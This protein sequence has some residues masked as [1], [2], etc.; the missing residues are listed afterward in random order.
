MRR[1]FS[2]W[3]ALALLLAITVPCYAGAAVSVQAR[4]AVL[5]DAESGRVL[6]AKEAHTKARIA[7]TTKLL[8]ALVAAERTAD[9]D[10]PIPIEPQWTGIEG[11][12]ICLKPG[13]TVS[14][15]L[16]LYGLL[17]Q[18]GNDAAV[19]I[20]NI[21]AGSEEDFAA[22]M[23]QRAAEIGMADSSFSNAS[24]LDGENHYSTAYDMALLARA[25]LANETVR[26]ICLARTA[27]IGERYF[28]NHNKLLSRYEGCIGMKTGYT[29]KAGR[30]LVSAAQKNGQTL[31][32][33]TLNDP[34]DWQDHAALL[35]YGFAAYPRASLCTEGEVFGAVPVSGSLIPS[36]TAVAHASAGYP[37]GAGE[38][39]E[40]SVSLTPSLT[41]PVRPGLAVGQVTWSLNGTTVAEVPLVSK[42]TALTDVKEPLS[43]WQR[44]AAFFRDLF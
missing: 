13:E 33:V 26:E 32:C 22:L 43:I 12:S 6:Y 31:I 24:G 8:T 40:R 15:R 16:L 28:V 18:S 44:I 25:C 42:D 30:T 14:L 3:T 39:L 36:I 11:S 10:K 23:N 27:R 37:L 1:G 29:E 9:L 35:D 20:A 34:D 7:S 4:C 2:I 5:M 41:A 17:L 21:V 38:V 19:A